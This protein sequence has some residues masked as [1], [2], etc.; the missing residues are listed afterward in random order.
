MPVAQE[1]ST[2]RMGNDGA[3]DDPATVGGKLAKVYFESVA[4]S[5][6]N[7]SLDATANEGENVAPHNNF[8]DS[9]NDHISR[10][11]KYHP[12]DR[13]RLLLDTSMFAPSSTPARVVANIP[14]SVWTRNR[15]LLGITPQAGAARNTDNRLVGRNEHVVNTMSAPLALTWLPILLR[16]QPVDRGRPFHQTALT[17]ST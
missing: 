11:V 8:I 17:R 16:Y 2:N 1:T 3:T 7:N 15:T 13:G 10:T 9:A 14:M 4:V 5:T 6:A 12:V